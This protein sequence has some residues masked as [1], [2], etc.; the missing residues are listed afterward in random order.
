MSNLAGQ[1]LYLR[2]MRTVTTDPDSFP[3]FDEELRQGLQQETELFMD[4][5]VR[6]DRSVLDLLSANY[7]FL[8]ERLARH[9]AIPNIYGS[10]LRRV[11]LGD[12]KR[13]GLLRQGSHPTVT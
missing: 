2:N 13:R 12:E 6:D 4:S 8:N 10:H 5:M 3:D 9:Y 1:W 11:P 7:T